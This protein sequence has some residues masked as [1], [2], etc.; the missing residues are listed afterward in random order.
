[1]G[2]RQV[3][4]INKNSD[5]YTF[6][7]AKPEDWGPHEDGTKILRAK[8]TLHKASPIEN[9]LWHGKFR[10]GSFESLNYWKPL[11][12]KESKRSNRISNFK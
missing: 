6:R 1:M 5:L 4:E 8:C 9:T 10:K 7:E 3:E 12:I 2:H 11:T